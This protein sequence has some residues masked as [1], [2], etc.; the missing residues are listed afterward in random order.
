MNG[1]DIGVGLRQLAVEGGEFSGGRLGGDGQL[2]GLLQQGIELIRLDVDAF[3][4]GLAAQGDYQGHHVHVVG[5]HLVGAEINIC[6][7]IG[8]DLHLY[9]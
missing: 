9:L 7:T 5:A 1:E 3:A 8:Y 2:V 6:S 4:V